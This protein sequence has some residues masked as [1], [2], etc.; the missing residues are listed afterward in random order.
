MEQMHQ[1]SC[2]FQLSPA[3]S[4]TGKGFVVEPNA[5]SMELHRWIMAGTHPC[6]FLRGISYFGIVAPLLSKPLA[7]ISLSSPTYPVKCAFL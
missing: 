2:F 5:A 1:M 6:R 4:V 3:T 7:I